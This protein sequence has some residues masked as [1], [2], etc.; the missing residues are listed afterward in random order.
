M[1]GLNNKATAMPSKNLLYMCLFF[2]TGFH[3]VD[4]AGFELT[5]MCLPGSAEIRKHEPPLTGYFIILFFNDLLGHKLKTKEQV[6][7]CAMAFGRL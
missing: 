7:N 2:K 5:K 4:Q 3:C 6:Q 1:L